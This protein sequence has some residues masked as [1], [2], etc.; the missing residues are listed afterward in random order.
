MEHNINLSR[1]RPISEHGCEIP[2]VA[3]EILGVDSCWKLLFKKS[4]LFK[5]VAIHRFPVPHG[6]TLYPC[7]YSKSKCTNNSIRK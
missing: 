7:I 6:I 2:R 4:L 5:N 1:I 3:E